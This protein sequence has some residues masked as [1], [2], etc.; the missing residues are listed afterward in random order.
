M[1]Q[2]SVIGMIIMAICLIVTYF[3]LKKIPPMFFGLTPLPSWLPR[4]LDLVLCIP[5]VAF[6]I[7]LLTHGRDRTSSLYTH[8]CR[9]AGMALG[10]G[11]GLSFGLIVPCYYSYKFCMLSSFDIAG[12][13][14]SI[15]AT[16]LIIAIVVAI[17]MNVPESSG[18]L[19]FMV[20]LVA[21]CIEL[22][23]LIGLNYPDVH[24]VLSKLI[25][26]MVIV[27]IVYQILL[28]FMVESEGIWSG[29]ITLGLGMGLG[30][31]LMAGMINGYIVGLGSTIILSISAYLL[32]LIGK[33]F[34]KEIP[35]LPE[36]I[37]VISGI[38]IH[39]TANCK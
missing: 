37:Y 38:N 23:F 4:P 28:F 19:I 17:L 26:I 34:G 5:Y 10:L 12:L 35:S 18:R 14:A 20:T 27:A 33:F 31:G 2:W 21:F 24:V 7:W 15:F 25:M 3:F 8:S 29:S 16:L 1:V 39:K 6:V 30:I 9:D 22:A 13:I 36:S 11:H 32:S